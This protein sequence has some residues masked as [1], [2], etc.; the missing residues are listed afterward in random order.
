MDAGRDD[1]GAELC[2][3]DDD[4]QMGNFRETL[5][6]EVVD[7]AMH[8]VN[9]LKSR[10]EGVMDRLRWDNTPDLGVVGRL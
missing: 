10:P 8:A 2:G 9:V 7:V 5:E 6:E 4:S 1:P 3:P